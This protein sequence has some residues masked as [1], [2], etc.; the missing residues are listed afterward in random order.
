MPKK[1]SSVGIAPGDLES[2]GSTASFKRRVA[3]AGRCL[4]T[5]KD[6]LAEFD[7]GGHI[8]GL[9]KGQFS[10]I[11]LA[12]AVLDKTGPADVGV[13]TWCIAEYEVEAFT[14]F[15]S[16][17]RVTKLR[18]VM[19]WAG[20]QR[21]MPLV[22][23]LQTRFGVDCIRVTKTH[24]KIVTVA[25]GDWRVVI[26]GSMNLNSNPRFEQ[27]DVSDDVA[28]FNL[29]DGMMTELWARGKALP[30]RELRHADATALLDAGEVKA[31]PPNWA[32]PADKKWW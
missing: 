13:W 23:E 7:W 10:M 12:A 28:A 4:S 30:V 9:T 25:A 6:A 21:D 18:V 29:V 2:K 15:F 14:A 32:P 26:R 19:D 8:F 1:F 27:F 20:A 17:R 22:G 5:A 24:A 11:D 16:D 3:A 31:P